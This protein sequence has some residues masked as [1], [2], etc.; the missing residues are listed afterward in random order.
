FFT[1]LQATTRRR[2]AR[3]WQMSR[4]VR[5]SPGGS[6]PLPPFLE[7]QISFRVL[8]GQAR[9]CPTGHLLSEW[10]SP[11]RPQ[12]SREIHSLGRERLCGGVAPGYQSKHVTASQWRLDPSA[13]ALSGHD[14]SQGS[15]PPRQGRGGPL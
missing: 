1:W 11:L 3:A 14:R 2:G 4:G 7:R 10:R 5:E 13:R 12:P 15:I 9:V 8:A 6:I